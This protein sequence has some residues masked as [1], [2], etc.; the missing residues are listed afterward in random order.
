MLENNSIL[1]NIFLFFFNGI[2]CKSF[3]INNIFRHLLPL[4]SHNKD[5]FSDKLQKNTL[6]ILPISFFCFGLDPTDG[7]QK[8]WL[9]FIIYLPYIGMKSSQIGAKEAWMVLNE[10]KK[11]ITSKIVFVFVKFEGNEKIFS[12]LFGETS[13]VRPNF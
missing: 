11:M 1:L 2:Y 4:T 13:N 10:F 6:G 5:S 12:I 9:I 7:I 3:K 8:L